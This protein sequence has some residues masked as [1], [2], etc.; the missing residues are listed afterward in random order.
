MI[1]QDH[2][3]QQMEEEAGMEA[4]RE[5]VLRQL[6]ELE[7]RIR[8]V[9]VEVMEVEKQQQEISYSQVSR[10]GEYRW[11]GEGGGVSLILQTTRLLFGS[12]LINIEKL[13][14][15]WLVKSPRRH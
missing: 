4:D 12:N 11:T 13:N 3:F 7:D 6:E 2:E 8:E 10:M 9:E 14:Q 1:F 15:V 5:E